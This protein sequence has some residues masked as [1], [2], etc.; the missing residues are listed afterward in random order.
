MTQNESKH[1]KFRKWFNHATAVRR[2]YNNLP[3][4]ESH[5]QCF[6]VQLEL[7]QIKQHIVFKMKYHVPSL[8]K[9]AKL[10]DRAKNA[11]VPVRHFLITET[12]FCAGANRKRMFWATNLQ[13]KSLYRGKMRLTRGKRP[14]LLNIV[15]TQ[16]NWLILN[17]LRTMLNFILIKYYSFGFV[18]YQKHSKQL[19]SKY[20]K[21]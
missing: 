11:Q 18:I 4:E 16:I 21:Y 13:N 7:F 8:Q 15:K 19:R 20:S 10:P 3:Y 2:Q 12:F 17:N 14:S 5:K 1:T 9:N 6:T